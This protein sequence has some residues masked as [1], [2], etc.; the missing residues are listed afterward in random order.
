MVGGF[1][2]VWVF[3]GVSIVVGVELLLCVLVVVF[4]VE[5]RLVMNFIFWFLNVF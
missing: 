2:V 4:G 3:D 5:I 1:V